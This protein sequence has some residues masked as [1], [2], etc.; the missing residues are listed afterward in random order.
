MEPAHWPTNLFAR[1]LVAFKSFL[2]R[3]KKKKKKKSYF[4]NIV[5][6]NVFQNHKLG[7]HWL[8]TDVRIDLYFLCFFFIGTYQFKDTYLI[9]SK[10]VK[11][12]FKFGFLCFVSTR[13][14]GYHMHFWCRKRPTESAESPGTAVTNGC[15][16]RS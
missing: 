5:S 8:F 15:V 11:V 7:T 3:M 16:P 4:I 10:P 13:V 14:S 1:A 12:C 6:R 9:N 2:S